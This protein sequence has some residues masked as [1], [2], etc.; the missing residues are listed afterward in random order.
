MLF[1]DILSCLT[2]CPWKTCWLTTDPG[3]VRN[4]DEAD[5]VVEVDPEETQDL[6]EP[7]V[8]VDVVE[9]DPGVEELPAVDQGGCRELL[10]GK[11]MQSLHGKSMQS[12]QFLHFVYFVNLYLNVCVVTIFSTLKMFQMI[13]WKDCWIL[14]KQR[15]NKNI[16]CRVER[17][18]AVRRLFLWLYR[19]MRRNGGIILFPFSLE[20]WWVLLRYLRSPSTVSLA[21]R[22]RK[23]TLAHQKHFKYNCGYLNQLLLKSVG[24]GEEGKPQ[25]FLVRATSESSSFDYCVSNSRTWNYFLKIWPLQDMQYGWT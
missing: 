15:I 23:S 3:S 13:A 24:R 19:Q 2:P 4:S 12:L 21:F 8:D 22:R 10:S 14:W 6:A 18:S 9:A 5:E 25:Q 1:L 17:S 7:A 20:T 11:S 16:K